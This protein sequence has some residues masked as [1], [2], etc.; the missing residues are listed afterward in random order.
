MKKEKTLEDQLFEIGLVFLPVS[1]LLAFL[2]L[3]WLREIIPVPPCVFYTYL[4]LYCPGCGGTRAVYALFHGQ[5]LKAVWFH[6]LVPYTAFLYVGFMGSR[7]LQKL[8]VP[9]IRGWK[10]HNWYLY[11]AIGITAGNFILKNVL[12][13]AFGISMQLL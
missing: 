1:A 8:H 7:L 5:L 10:F 13:L 3:K 12:K 9:G 6:P 11:A 4:G 2:Y